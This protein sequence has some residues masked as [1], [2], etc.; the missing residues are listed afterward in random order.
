VLV[1]EELKGPVDT[2]EDALRAV[3]RRFGLGPL[4]VKQLLAEEL[5]AETGG[6]TLCQS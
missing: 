6:D 4:Y 2:F 3:W 1:G 5:A